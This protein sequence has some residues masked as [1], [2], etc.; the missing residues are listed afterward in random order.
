MDYFEPIERE[1]L[2]FKDF[3]RNE[4]PDSA[5]EIVST[6]KMSKDQI[7]YLIHFKKEMRKRKIDPCRI[8]EGARKHRIWGYV[9]HV[10]QRTESSSSWDGG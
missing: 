1:I 6:E 4:C 5:D 7:R 8:L 3:F 10:W 2:S 9:L